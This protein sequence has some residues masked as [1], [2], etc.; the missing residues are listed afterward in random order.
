MLR[1]HFGKC[2]E[3]RLGWKDPDHRLAIRNSRQIP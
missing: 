3:Q 1:W 2:L